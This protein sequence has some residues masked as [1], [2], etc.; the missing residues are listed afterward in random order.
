ML[1]RHALFGMQIYTVLFYREFALRSIEF[2][3]FHKI[4]YNF[5]D[6]YSSR[7]KIAL[8]PSLKVRS[9]VPVT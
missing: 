4:I 5:S 7:S 2:L 6:F 3:I 8:S 1:L 9:T